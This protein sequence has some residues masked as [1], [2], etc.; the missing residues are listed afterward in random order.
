M[1]KNAF[2]IM[3]SIVIFVESIVIRDLIT[4][5]NIEIHEDKNK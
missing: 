2:N 4:N 5:I 1:V 3:K